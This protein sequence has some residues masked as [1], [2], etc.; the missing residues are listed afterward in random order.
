MLKITN[1][2]FSDGLL[3]NLYKIIIYLIA[4]AIVTVLGTLRLK[5]KGKNDYEY[6]LIILCFI[7]N[8]FTFEIGTI[9]TII[10]ALLIVSIKSLINKILNKGKKYNKLPIAFYI[11]IS[12][13]IVWITIFL[14]QIGG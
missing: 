8:F 5:K 3:T 6:S 9:L 12:N 1:L 13:A 14:S 7:I 2:A 10:F 11:C 4:I